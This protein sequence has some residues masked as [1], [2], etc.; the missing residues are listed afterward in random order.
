M[1]TVWLKRVTWALFL[2]GL[3]AGTSAQT[4]PPGCNALAPTDALYGLGFLVSGDGDSCSAASFSSA[5]DFFDALTTSALSTLDPG[6]TGEEPAEL[7][8][9]F[10]SLPISLAYPNFG[11]TDVEGG[12]RLELSIPALGVFEVFEGVDRD[13]S[14][15]LLEDYLKNSGI[16]GRIMKYQ[17]ANSP[18]SPIAGPGGLIPTAVAGDFA[19]VFNTLPSRAEGAQ[20]GSFGVGISHASLSVKG[21]KTRVTTIPLSYT[22]RN[23]ID[24]R[25]QLV[26]SM[27]VTLSDTDGAESYHLAPGVSYRLPMNDAWTIAPAARVG[28]VYS[29]DIAT[30]AGV[31]SASVAS[32]YVIRL[33]AFDVAIG[34][35][36]GYYT[37]TKIKSGDYSFDPDIDNFVLRNG[38]MLNQPVVLGGRRLSVEYSLIDTRYLGTDIYVDNTQEVGITVGTNRSALSSRSFIRG[39]LSYLHGRDTHGLSVNIG[40]WF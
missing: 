39:G 38:V 37:T 17:A 14:E 40:Y 7:N 35:M 10:N 2:S 26:F 18:H 21:L 25:R 6:Y 34:N 32:T 23:N 3:A 33:T 8:V 19:E 36:L 11:F 29:P 20:G 27:P 1:A 30:V 15:E 28:L 24:P 9:F 4:V 12:S 5:E 13:A 31:L 22:L 16:I